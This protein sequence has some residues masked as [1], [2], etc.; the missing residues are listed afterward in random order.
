MASD[1]HLENT[2]VNP[3]IL[4]V[5][6]ELIVAENLARNLI[7]QGYKVV[8][9]VGSGAGAIAAVQAHSP[10]LV[11]MDV[12]LQGDVDGV[13]AAEQINRHHSIPIIY[14]TA[15]SDAT[16]LE[17]AKHTHPY[18]YLVKPFNPN[19]LRVTLEVALQ[20]F[21][22]DSQALAA[23]NAQLQMAR[24]QLR[25]IQH[26]DALTGVLNEAGLRQYFD[27]LVGQ[28]PAPPG[29]PAEPELALLCLRLDRF[30]RLRQH[31][32]EIAQQILVQVAKR[33]SDTLGSVGAV[34]RLDSC[35]FAILLTSVG[36]KAQVT[37]LAHR[38][39]GGIAPPLE[40]GNQEVFVQASLGYSLYPHQGR[41]FCQLLHQTQTLVDRLQASG[42]NRCQRYRDAAPPAQPPPL[43]L[44]SSLHHALERQELSL[45]YQPKISLSTGQ[46]T[47][48][49]ALLRWHHPQQGTISPLDFIPL[50]EISGLINPIGDWVLATACKQLRCWRD[51]G[52]EGLRMAVNLSSIQ[53][54]N[55]QLGRYIAHCMVE[56]SILPN[57]LELE[58]TESTIV[59]DMVA[60]VRYLKGLKTLGTTIAIDDFGTGYSSLN[61]IH[62]LPIDVLKLDRAF[63]QNIHLPGSKNAV[64]ARAVIAMAHELNIK[65]VAEGVSDLAE[66]QFLIKNHVDEAQGYLISPPLS[67]PALTDWLKHRLTDQSLSQLLAS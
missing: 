18:G 65:V 53:I 67:A 11:L 49:E 47:G 55:S 45:V 34:A 33:L 54:K 4:I 27:T 43:S 31:G 21:R 22:A 41:S 16:T 32:A 9:I 12:M 40:L 56:N 59:E 51:Q 52:F 8:D 48:V 26:H 25:Q 7:K 63:V 38:L 29:S 30:E 13:T 39:W 66:L 46:V 10:D 3:R 28:V 35:E 20:K 5:E 62:Q 2:F 23:Q 61:Y 24:H 50:A 42:G 60:A 44:E 36:Q 37:K 57:T 58:L 14:M 64:I 17:R 1:L 15:Y 19:M 6:D